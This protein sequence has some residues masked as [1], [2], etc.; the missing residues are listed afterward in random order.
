MAG[1]FWLTGRYF[2]VR[3]YCSGEP[4]KRLPGAIGQL[5]LLINLI[6]SGMAVYWL[7]SNQAF[8]EEEQ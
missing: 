1:V 7:L 5:G 2:Y 8:E 4:D 3:G 6:N